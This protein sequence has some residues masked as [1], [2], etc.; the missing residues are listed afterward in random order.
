[1]SWTGNSISNL[2]S[3]CGL[4]D[5]RIRAFDKDLPVL[6]WEDDEE[7]TEEEENYNSEKNSESKER[8]LIL[9]PDLEVTLTLVPSYCW[10]TTNYRLELEGIPPIAAEALLEYIYKDS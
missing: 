4:V 2:S 3:C 9:D 5:A 1:M 6:D 10:G 8:H 7:D